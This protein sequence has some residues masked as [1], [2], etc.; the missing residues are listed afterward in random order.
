[1][2]SEIRKK[3]KAIAWLLTLVYFASYTTRI[4]FAVMMVKICSEMQT[5]K[6]AL[7]G[8]VT[9][10]TVTYGAGQ[11]ISGLMGDKIKPQWMLTF[12]LGLAG[13]TNLIMAFCS[14]IPLMTVVWG[15]NGFAQAMLWPPIVRLMST[16]LN[17]VEY[18]YS[19]VRVSW[20][21]SFST[22]LL[23]LVCP[24]LLYVISWRT[25]MILCA[26]IGIGVMVFWTAVNPKLLNEPLAGEKK[27]DTSAIQPQKNMPIP[28]FVYLPV[29]LIILGIVL[30][31]ILRD[32]V[33]N[34]MPFYLQETFHIAE[35]N[36]IICTV[37]LALFSVVSFWVFDFL[38]RRLF[39]NEVF[40]AAVIFAGAAVSAALLYLSNLVSA[41]VAISMILMALIVAF[42]HGINLMLI[43][44]VPK[45]FVKSGKVATFSGL[46][47][48]FTYVGA[49]LSTYG[50]AI[51]SER[52][53]WNVT[54]LLWIAVSAAGLIVCLAATPLWKRF[55]H[56]YADV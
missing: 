49:S 22:I 35:E 4:N 28:R 13:V 36:A 11:I 14:S 43:T 21:S 51:L 46:L 16:Y 52:F 48:A 53:G 54:I 42:M 12:G 23:Y 5:D 41:S 45:R 39:K 44:V 19:A 15:I 27:A 37:I 18:G 33:T 24:L 10:L 31:G 34:W 55:R 30:Q 26:I 50:F 40:C 6:T 2:Q 17:D 47:N 1:M 32:G 7:A 9:A 29:V 25:V 56:D 8:I 3:G 38:H 20:G